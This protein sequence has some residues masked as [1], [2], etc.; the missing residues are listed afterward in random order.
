MRPDIHEWLMQALIFVGL[1]LVLILAVIGLL[2]LRR[3]VN[4]KTRFLREEIEERSR[5]EKT[6]KASE[7]KFKTLFNVAA[8]PMCHVDGDGAIIGFNP[9]FTRL[10]G[11]TLEDIPTLDEWWPRAY[12][13]K[14][15]RKWVIAT[16]D[17][18]VNEAN[19]AGKDI[20]PVEYKVTCKTGEVRNV[21]IS[22]SIFEDQFLATFYDITDQKKGEKQLKN[23]LEELERSNAELQEFAYVASHDLQEPL[24]AT[25]GFLQL[26]QTKYKDR[27]DEKAHHYIDRAIK[28]THR[29]QGLIEELLALSQV[30]VHPLSPT[31][32][33]LNRVLTDTLDSLAPIIQ[34]KNAVV[35][36]KTMPPIKGDERQ[37][38]SLFQNLIMNALKYNDHETSTVEIGYSEEGSGPCFY[39]KDNGIGIAPEHHEKI[40]MIFKRL[41]T[42][43]A[44]SG[45]GIGLALCQK[46][47]ERH[48]GTLW[49]SST[50]SKGATFF[51]TLP[52]NG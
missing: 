52:Q 26:L 15:Y 6:I 17:R 21:I 18:M 10:F 40:F 44:Y 46:I 4:V 29:M 36:C 14:D 20:A 34:E 30:N 31:P 22:G 42:R 33:D 51:F 9:K 45:S 13:D 38:Q 37:I 1:P 39:V 19:Q 50:S 32:T 25:A 28:S 48:G 3:E 2:I 23:T 47:V 27:L 35:H 24:R 11:Y 8:I 5:V 7:A 43:K 16:W 41:H 12:P 49:V